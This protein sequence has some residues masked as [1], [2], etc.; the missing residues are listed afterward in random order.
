M[1]RKSTGDY[2]EDWSE[3]SR[4][5]KEEAGWCCERCHHPN[6]QKSGHVL[7]VHHLDINPANNDWWNLAVLC[8]RCH[9]HIQN[10]VRLDQPYMFDHSGWF[11]PHVAGYYAS[12]H[13][14]PTNWEWV[15]NH[16]EFL[17]D[18]GRVKNV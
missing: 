4:H 8:Q 13:G 11:K 14:H 12:L 16:L 3:I 6:D 9:L 15:M 2:P 18:Y 7:T 10:K 17:L 5:A 1:T